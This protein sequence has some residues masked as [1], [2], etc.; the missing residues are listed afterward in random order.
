MTK[1]TLYNKNIISAQDFTHDAVMDVI[2]LAQHFK[3]NKYATTLN[4]KI[5]ANCF[6]ESSTRTRFSF[7]VAT[8]N[9]GGKVIACA[10]QHESSLSK[11][12][13][14]YDTVKVISAYADALVIR[15]AYEGAASLAAL[16]A[17]CPVI[18]A[19]DG[20]NQHPTQSLVD[21]FSIYECQQKI[22]GL[23][24]ALVGDL[25]YG[26]TIHSLTQLFTLFDDVRLYLV[27]PEILSLPDEMCDLL[28]R[29]GIRFSFHQ[30][31][32]EVIP[33]VD[34]LYMTR[35]QKERC[36][37]SEYQLALNKFILA[38]NLLA[39]ARPNLKIL[40]PLPRV[41]ELAQ[42][43][44]QTDYAYYFTQAANAVPVRQALLT[45]LLNEYL[46]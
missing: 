17:S 25:K 15:H 37:G 42:D 31:L 29:Q 16:A 46:S 45:L 5:I 3:M 43:I 12:E 28:K 40:H 18:N 41:T 26:R 2:A 9:L 10:N 14:L 24:I 19:G 20:A 22:D 13:S 33:L 35:I 44:D 23:A 11:G 39:Q 36:V 7:E 32:A 4:N 6:F 8:L 38:K 30:D 1:S 21:L 27:A 34:I